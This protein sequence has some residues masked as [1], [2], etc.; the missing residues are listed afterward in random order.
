MRDAIQIA[1]DER[2]DKIRYINRSVPEVQWEDRS[3]GT[4]LVSQLMSKEEADALA[5]RINA[6]KIGT[7]VVVESRQSETKGQYRVIINTKT[8]SI[9]ELDID[10]KNLVVAFL[11]EVYGSHMNNFAFINTQWKYS[12]VSNEIVY[13]GP[14][15]TYEP[16]FLD[17]GFKIRDFIFGRNESQ[18]QHSCRA[19]VIE[20]AQNYIIQESGRHGA[21]YHWTK[22]GILALNEIR[23]RYQS[24]NTAGSS[25]TTSAAARRYGEF[26]SAADTGA[27]ASAATNTASSSNADDHHFKTGTPH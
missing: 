11:N 14:S 1:E 20:L 21:A 17:E 24:E 18:S 4:Q 25:A 19:E 10:E 26:F 6:K 15:V 22:S 12:V 7:F 3:K 5:E 23:E 8:V 13:F 16:L 27:A 2:N 9:K